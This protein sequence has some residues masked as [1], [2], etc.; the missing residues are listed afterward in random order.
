MNSV[1]IVSGNENATAM[2]VGLIKE[3]SPSQITMVLNGAEAR[4]SLLLNDY[5]VIIINCPMTDEFGHS[6]AEY[7]SESTS[8]GCIMIVKND[9][10]DQVCAKVE[11]FGIMVVS[12]PLNRAIF[13]QTLKLAAASSK[14]MAVIQN[15]NNRLQS[16][17]EEMR[18]V[19]RAKCALIQYLKL[20]EPQAH[21]YIE[22]QAMDM[23][24]TKREVSLSIIKTYEC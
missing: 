5:D 24:Q 11:D 14:R 12:K 23:R 18:L 2:L 19:D 20:T 13:H 16:K 8:A 21:R 6:L 17:I 1:L 22:K 3:T 10:C 15:E 4:R 9:L 7:I